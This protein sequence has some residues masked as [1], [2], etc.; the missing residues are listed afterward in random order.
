MPGRA[1]DKSADQAAALPRAAS[2]A[3]R[4]AAILAAYASRVPPLKTAEPATSTLAPA[5]ATSARGL[6]RDA[7]VDLD[8]DRPRADHRLD[9]ADLVDARRE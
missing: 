1:E 7:A 5:A 2:A 9:A 3:E 8:V 4:M 6:R